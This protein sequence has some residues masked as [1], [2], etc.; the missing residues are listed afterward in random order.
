MV[1]TSIEHDIVKAGQAWTCRPACKAERVV[2]VAVDSYPGGTVVN[3]L[4]ELNHESESLG[5]ILAPI[6]FSCLEPDLVAV[7]AND[8]NVSPH[9]PGYT[10]WK[11]LANEGQAGVWTCAI[12]TIIATLNEADAL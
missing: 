12:E 2:I 1:Y 11:R 8:V 5:Q 3:I 10:E 4:I 9:I 7:V 6:A